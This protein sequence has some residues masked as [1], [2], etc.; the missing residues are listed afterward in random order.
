[1]TSEVSL[2]PIT[3]RNRAEVEALKV[4]PG[5]ERFVDGV[6][7]SFRDAEENPELRPWYR[8]VTVGSTAVGFLMLADDVPPGNPLVPWRFYLWRM[9]IDER[10]QGRGH[11]RAALDQLVAYLRTRPGA[12]TLMT[13]VVPAEPDEGSPLGFYLAYGFRPTGE[14]YDHEDV[15]EL[16]LPPI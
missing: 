15:L 5:Q 11:G 4:A 8:A 10:Y 16:T 7:R 3:D 9:L 13:S 1:M 6:L 12:D 14:R 2:Q